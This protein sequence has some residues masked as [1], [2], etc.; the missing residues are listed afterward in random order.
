MLF[1]Q[2]LI[3]YVTTLSSISKFL[4]IWILINSIVLSIA[5]EM[6]LMDVLFGKSDIGSPSRV[7]NYRYT[8]LVLRKQCKCRT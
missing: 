7:I 1:V 2:S 5:A 4:L 6:K 8:Y 3:I